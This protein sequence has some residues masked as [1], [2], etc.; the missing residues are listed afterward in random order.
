MSDDFAICPVCGD[1]DMSSYNCDEKGNIIEDE[2]DTDFCK[3]K[4]CG[5]IIN[6][7]DILWE[8]KEYY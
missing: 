1:Y 2:F 5:A 6:R 8:H 4:K 7:R 3:C